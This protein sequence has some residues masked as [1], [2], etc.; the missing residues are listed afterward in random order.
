MQWLENWW[1]KSTGEV[2]D[3][4]TERQ[5]RLRWRETSTIDKDL[6]RSQTVMRKQ[7]RIDKGTVLQGRLSWKRTGIR[8][9]PEKNIFK[10]IK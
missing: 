3:R 4:E 6:L 2:I 8:G 5:G 7:S 1:T 10:K 9:E